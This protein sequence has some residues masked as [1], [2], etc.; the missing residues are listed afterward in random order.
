VHVKVRYIHSQNPAREPHH[1]TLESYPHTQ[2]EFL[3]KYFNMVLLLTH[4]SLPNALSLL[5]F[6]NTVWC[7]FLNSVG[8]DSSVGIAT[9]YVQN[10]PGSN[11]GEE[12]IFRTHTD[13]RWGPPNLLFSW[14]QVSF[15]G[16]KR[17]ERG[18]DNSFLSFD[19]VKEGVELYLYPLWA[20]SGV[21]FTL[22]LNSPTG[23]PFHVR[24]IHIY[25][26]MI[27][28]EFT[29]DLVLCY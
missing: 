14:Y 15:P 19:E 28:V 24:I 3:R 23:L 6:S 8:R 7:E 4:I 17:L 27:I 2:K 13:R 9:C 26:I 29:S 1:E 18:V 12:E 5:A 11:P 10:G 25:L 22:F 21:N 20:C 16:V